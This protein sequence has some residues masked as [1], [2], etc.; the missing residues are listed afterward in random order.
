[1]GSL[2]GGAPKMP[3]P[4]P[5]LPPQA[6]PATMAN[7]QVQMVGAAAR[8]RAGAAAASGTVGAS[9]PRGLTDSLQ[10]SKSTLLGGTSAQ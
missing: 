5:P 8:Q 6:A 2:F 9:G 7:P 10:T 1:M 3:P 4:P